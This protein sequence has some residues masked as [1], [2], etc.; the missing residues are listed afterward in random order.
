MSYRLRF[1]PLKFRWKNSEGASTGKKN[2]KHGRERRYRAS[3]RGHGEPPEGPL[4]SPPVDVYEGEDRFVILADVPG[5]DPE[6]I[7]ISLKGDEMVLFA[8][9]A[10]ETE[11]EAISGEYRVGHWYRRFRVEGVDADAAEAEVHNGV[12]TVVLPKAEDA[13]PRRIEITEK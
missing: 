11:G 12:L 9:V 8:P 7:D 13:A 5:A 10:R 4:F 2:H 1:G 6:R 3:T